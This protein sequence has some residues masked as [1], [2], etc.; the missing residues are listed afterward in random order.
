MLHVQSCCLL[1]WAL[2]WPRNLGQINLSGCQKRNLKNTD[3]F[4]PSLHTFPSRFLLHNQTTLSTD[5]VNINRAKQKPGNY[6]PASTYTWRHCL[7]DC[8]VTLEADLITQSL[9]NV[10]GIR[11]YSLRELLPWI[12]KHIDI[13]RRLRD[14]LRRKR[15]AKWRTSI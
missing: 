11:W 2:N 5:T 13:L 6:V 4:T 8:I 10:P 9:Q 15:P 12:K 14:A 1:P 7:D 3:C